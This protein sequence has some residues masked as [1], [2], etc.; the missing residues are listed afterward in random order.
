MIKPKP[1]KFIDCGACENGTNKVYYAKDIDKF[2]KEIDDE[3]MFIVRDYNLDSD[4]KE[5][6]LRKLAK[7]M[8]D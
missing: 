5:M 6:R 2:H 1:V 4:D 7:V 3:I 8:R